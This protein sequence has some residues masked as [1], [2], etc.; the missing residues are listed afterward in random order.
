MV[1]CKQWTDA[2]YLAV[3]FFDDGSYSLSVVII[4]YFMKSEC[5]YA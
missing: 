2:E 3:N 4:C 1:G 5:E